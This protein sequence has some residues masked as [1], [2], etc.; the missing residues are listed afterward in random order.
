M[1]F[2]FGK[3]FSISI[4]FDCVFIIGAVLI[5]ITLITNITEYNLTS[6]AVDQCSVEQFVKESINEQTK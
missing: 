6:L 4:D 1:T 5:L 3:W 2:N